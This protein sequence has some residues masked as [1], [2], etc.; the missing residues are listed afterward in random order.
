[1]DG[2]RK[3]FDHIEEY[4]LIILLPLMVV[5]VFTATMSRYFQLFPM[6]WSEELARYIMVWLAYIGASLG[7][8]RGAH[9]GIDVLVN[10]LP[11]KLRPLLV[12]LRLAII[13]IFAVL[14]LFYAYQIISHQQRIGQTSPALLIPIWWAYLAVPVGCL[15]IGVRSIQVFIADYKKNSAKKGGA[16]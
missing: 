12:F 16:L 10:A 4:M 15:M 8:K 6:P 7:I 13:L 2:L 11:S 5:L 14:I 9:L 1:M 3:F